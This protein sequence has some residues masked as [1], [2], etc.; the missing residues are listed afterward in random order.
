MAEHPAY[1]HT[2]LDCRRPREL[3]EF[4]AAA[5]RTPEGGEALNPDNLICRAI[6]ALV[7]DL[8]NRMDDVVIM[9][10][11]EFGRTVAENGS[12]GTALM[13]ATLF[14]RNQMVKLVLEAGA[15]TSIRD[16]R[17]LTALDLAVQQGNEEA[18]QMLQ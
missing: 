4:Y 14:G 15:D 2:V 5:L 7:T 1:A 9:T 13:F 17:G 11:S 3:A 6:A 18:L 16:V 12:G 8:G 10:M